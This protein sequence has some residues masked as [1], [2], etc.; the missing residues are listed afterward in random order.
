MARSNFKDGDIVAASDLNAFGVEI[1]S[2]STAVGNRLLRTTLTASSPVT[3]GSNTYTDYVVAIQAGGAV[4]LP[5]AVGNTSRYT[6]KNTTASSVTVT[7]TGSEKV[8]GGS[9]V[10]GAA[11][12]VDLVSDGTNWMVV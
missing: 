5:T 9:L 12:S 10:I 7:T 2:L 3:L 8:D 1:N 4:T 11:A 6:L